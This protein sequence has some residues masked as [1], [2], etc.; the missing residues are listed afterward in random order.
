MFIT[1]SLYSFSFSFFVITVLSFKISFADFESSVYILFRCV[2]CYF[3]FM[4]KPFVLYEFAIVGGCSVEVS[5]LI[6]KVG[7]TVYCTI[8]A[9]LF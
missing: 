5:L 9:L 2:S 8:H 1:V 7:H 4:N 6:L 3:M